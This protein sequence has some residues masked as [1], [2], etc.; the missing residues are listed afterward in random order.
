MWLG[1]NP[2]HIRRQRPKS[3]VLA[4]LELNLRVGEVLLVMPLG[5]EDIGRVVDVLARSERN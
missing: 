1:H 3:P 4:P 2:R 5:R